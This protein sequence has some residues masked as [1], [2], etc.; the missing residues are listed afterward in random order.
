MIFLKNFFKII[1]NKYWIIGMIIGAFLLWLP[2]YFISWKDSHNMR[3]W[4]WDTYYY[5]MLWLDI[6]LTI[7]F[8]I[9]VWAT[10]YKI[11]KMWNVKNTNKLWF[12]GGF[13]GTIVWWCA[14]CSITLATYLWLAGF[15]SLLPY[16]GLELKII[17]IIILI[18]VC[19]VSVRDIDKCKIKFKK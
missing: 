1:S 6:T 2:S 7:L 9:F 5:F 11:I 3:M 18:Y 19:F 10:L 13:I 4:M 17:S 12:I 16:N 15:I 14:S 8:A